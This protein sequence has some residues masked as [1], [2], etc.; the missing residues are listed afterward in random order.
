MVLLFSSII[1]VNGLAKLSIVRLEGRG[2]IFCNLF[3]NGD[4]DPS[5]NK[6]LVS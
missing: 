6:K 2:A 3:R 5:G 1:R 4:N